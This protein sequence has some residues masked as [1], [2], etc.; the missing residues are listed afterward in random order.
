R[1]HLGG[2]FVELVDALDSDAGAEDVAPLLHVGQQQP[3]PFLVPSG[4]IDMDGAGLP[5]QA[6]GDGQDA[7]IGHGVTTICAT[8]Q[9]PVAAPTSTPS[10]N[11]A[12]IQASRVIGATPLS[13]FWLR[14]RYASG[15]RLDV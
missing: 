4:R 14:G 7:R 12:S 15:H 5:G 1:R 3:E 13:A 2:L 9:R 8:I 6:L 10:T 11:A